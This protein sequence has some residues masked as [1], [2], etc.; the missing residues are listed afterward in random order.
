MCLLHAVVQDGI[1]SE[2]VAL[3]LQAPGEEAG[4]AT[5]IEDSE[6]IALNL[7]LD[8]EIQ[9]ESPAQAD[10][11]MQVWTWHASKT[12]ARSGNLNT[13]VSA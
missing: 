11:C 7:C 12:P 1:G 8:S 6:G 9:P 5:A 2:P 4:V 3:K 10:T 13:C